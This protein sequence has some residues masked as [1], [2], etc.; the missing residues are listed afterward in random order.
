MWTLSGDSIVNWQCTEKSE[1]NKN[2]RGNRGECTGG[3]KSDA[4]LV[5]ECRKV[6]YSG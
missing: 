4:R 1:E 5:A 2:E 3:E 6:I